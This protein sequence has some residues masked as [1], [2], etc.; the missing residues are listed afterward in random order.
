M[1]TPT[2][3]CKRARHEHGTATMY[4]VHQCRCGQCRAAATDRARERRREQL[5]GR[6][7]LTDAEPAR[8]HVRGLMAQGMGWK[9]IADAA[10]ISRSTLNP[11]LW[12]R[13]GS[14]PRPMRKQINRCL[15]AKLLAVKYELV[16]GQ[17]MG[18]L[19]SLRR[20][21]ALVAM[22]W[23]QNCLAKRLGMEPSNFGG[24]INGHWGGIRVT[25]AE[26]IEEVFNELWDKTPTG[27]TWQA[28]GGITRA[29]KEAHAKGWVTAAAWDDID[30]PDEEP[31]AHLI[32]ET[33]DHRSIPS[34]DKI[35]RLELLTHDGYGD[36]DDTFVRAGWA[37]RASA[38][39]VLQR[40]DRLDLVE[41]LQRND[42]SRLVA[43]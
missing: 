10:G 35:D 8:Q 26:K 2:C 16:G 9:S 22:G 43:S 41:R 38:W 4:K 24:I 20:L 39:K 18:N 12:A 15:E 1:L 25:T 29:K 17:V 33:V 6:H 13:A 37:S 31:K 7:H 28:R 11:I 21:R 19:G 27:T 14:D 42:Q 32:D 23:S 40:M 30:D 3:D 34:L 5:Y 36:T